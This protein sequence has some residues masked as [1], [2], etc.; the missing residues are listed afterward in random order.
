MVDLVMSLADMKPNGDSESLILSLTF[1]S[2]PP[3]S[4]D[5]G[6]S[7]LPSWRRR[8]LEILYF[9]CCLGGGCIAVVRLEIL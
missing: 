3:W 8:F 1:I 7:A 5:D 4:G 2:K 9:R 6:V